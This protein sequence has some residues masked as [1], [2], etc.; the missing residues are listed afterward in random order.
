[1]T[2]SGLGDANARRDKLI[3]A[4][5][6]EHSDEVCAA[7]LARIDEYVAA[8]LDGQDYVALFPEVALHLDAC[9]DCTGAYARIYDTEWAARMNAL[10]AVGRM[11]EPDLSF[12]GAESLADRLRDAVRRVGGRLTLSLSPD[13][14]PLLRPTPS[15]V[16]LR[17]PQDTRRYHETLLT[18]EPTPDLPIGLAAYRDAQRPQMC[19]VEVTV[20]PPDRAWPD[21]GGIEVALATRD[22]EQFGV[23]DDWGLASFE[24]VP[25]DDLA[26]LMVSV[27]LEA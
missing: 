2:T 9:L 1:M 20:E 21:L 4:I 25:V 14:L 6:T 18:L 12:L 8:Q 10:P 11:T 19:L 15:A 3:Q 7:C 17:A 23:T 27:A 13:L 16:A 26:G 24:N 5:Q 22:A